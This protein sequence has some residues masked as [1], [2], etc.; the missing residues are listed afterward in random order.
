[1]DDVLRPIATLREAYRTRRV[2][3]VEVT[4]AL[5]ERAE[6]LQ[7]T[8]NAF[9]TITGERALEQ[10][11][12][13]ERGLM[14]GDGEREW[15][16]RPLLG[17]PISLKDLY[18]QRGVVTTAGTSGRRNVVA[19]KDATVVRRLFRAG[20]ISLGKTNTHELA[21]GRAASTRTLG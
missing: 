5:L 2:S 16:R 3:P 13:A 15:E 14:K 10:A 18:D 1:M 17:V 21:W 7:P 20:A 12:A 6:R 9:I 11:R 19:T 8:I 4:R